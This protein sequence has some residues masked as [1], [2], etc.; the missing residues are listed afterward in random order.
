MERQ[1]KVSTREGYLSDSNLELSD[2][3]C[4]QYWFAKFVV[5]S[6]HVSSRA[7]KKFYQRF[8]KAETPFYF[9]HSLFS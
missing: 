8:L 2:A 5:S 9:V 6:L 7:Q 3:A 4:C 1:L